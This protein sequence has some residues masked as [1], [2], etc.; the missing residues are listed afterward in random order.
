M[1][2]YYSKITYPNAGGDTEFSIPFEYL[3]QSHIAV[4]L[5]DV[6]QTN[7]VDYTINE[8]TS[9]VVFG[10]PTT[11]GYA[12]VITRTTPIATDD[13]AVTFTDGSGLNADDLNDSTKQNI[14]AIQ[15]FSDDID[16]SIAIV[17]TALLKA[18]NL[19]DVT[20]AATSRT[21]L[22]V[23]SKSET[24]SLYADA[25]G[26]LLQ[27]NNLSDVDSA[28]TSRTNLGLGTMATQDKL[29]VDITG[30]T[31]SGVSI[32]GGTI[33]T[34]STDLAVSDGGTGAS[35]SI[36][37]FDNLAPTTTK[38]DLIVSDGTNNVRVG[39][40]ADGTIP[41]ADSSDSE[42]IAWGYQSTL[43]AQAY[44]TSAQSIASSTFTV[45]VF[46]GEVFDTDNCHNTSTG[47]F[48][49]TRAGY[50]QVSCSASF[51]SSSMAANEYIYATIRKNGGSLFCSRMESGNGINEMVTVSGCIYCNGST[52]YIDI[53][54]Y[55][56]DATA[57]NL[58]AN[59][60]RFS[61]AF[62]GN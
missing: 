4:T 53:Q 3:E 55:Q 39:V 57:V 15:E 6:S 34:L 54:V 2:T 20:N 5:N 18:N 27:S 42:G 13:L 8:S 21:N 44:L 33:S 1:T 36:A 16:D 50:Y 60:T 61:V 26:A 46:D 43:A 49:P 48:T 29:G 37:A 45:V 22:D 28:A 7:G 62:I 24:D 35:T 25:T 12:V 10:S 17:D 9:K 31:M 58:L 56:T 30:G 40:G 32:S 52:D 47:V 51:E 59:D 14:F 11:A 41:V 23:Y 19:S 38:G